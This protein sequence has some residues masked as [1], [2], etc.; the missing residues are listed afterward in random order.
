[1]RSEASN[2]I[3]HMYLEGA[4]EGGGLW[5]GLKN[6]EKEMTMENEREFSKDEE[7]KFWPKELTKVKQNKLLITQC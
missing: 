1:M 2:R 4:L 6:G 5:G 7:K 3:K